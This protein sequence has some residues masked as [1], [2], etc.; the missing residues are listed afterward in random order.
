MGMDDLA[1]A[2]VGF[3]SKTWHDFEVILL[4]SEKFLCDCYVS[5]FCL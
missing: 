5:A 1:H 3:C 4:I 2:V